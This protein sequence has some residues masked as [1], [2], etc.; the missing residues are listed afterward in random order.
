MYKKGV[1]N[2]ITL[3][4]RNNDFSFLKCLCYYLG[5]YFNCV[6]IISILCLKSVSERKKIKC[7]LNCRRKISSEKCYLINWIYKIYSEFYNH[8]VVKKCYVKFSSIS[9]KN[10]AEVYYFSLIEI[11]YHCFG[12]ISNEI[13]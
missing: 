1:D 5:K 7:L 13:Y 4:G 10:I 9:V 3:H 12:S 6:I 8:K 2:S 11:K